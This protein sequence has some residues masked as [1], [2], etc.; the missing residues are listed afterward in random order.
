MFD[1]FVIITFH[2][3]CTAMNFDGSIQGG[4]QYQIIKKSTNSKLRPS[5]EKMWMNELLQIP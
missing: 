1:L 2:G 4:V 3:H 5:G